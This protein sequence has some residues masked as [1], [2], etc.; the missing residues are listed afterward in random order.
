[1]NNSYLIDVIIPVYNVNAYIEQCIDS[2]IEVPDINIIVVDD[3]SQEN[4]DFLLEKYGFYKNFNFYR[5]QNGGLSSARNFGI[6]KA[7]AEY[8]MFLDGDDFIKTD[9][10]KSSIEYIKNT[11]KNAYFYGYEN[12]FEKKKKYSKG[13]CFLYVRD[14]FISPKLLTEMKKGYFV[15]YAWR[16][17][18]KRQFILENRLFFTEGLYF[19][20]QEWT[21][22]LL[23]TLD[24]VY[25]LKVPLYCYRKDR[26]GSIMSKFIYKHIADTFRVIELLND[27]KKHLTDMDKIRFIENIILLRY[28]FVVSNS[29]DVTIEDK[30]T[31]GKAV[32]EAQ[33]VLVIDKN[34]KS[35][36]YKKGTIR[37]ARFYLKMR[38]LKNKILR[39]IQGNS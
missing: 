18:I 34:I 1:M 27:Y 9:L 4:T 7:S 8:I 13:T 38:N 37:M 31:F 30:A 23:C 24:K 33:R 39:I 19:E 12:F 26:E 14:D 32:K 15:M 35:I 20:D 22:R 36:I 28:E 2:V 10:L 11:K 25:S 16:Y 21:P 6:N 17:I 29:S 3:G 5:K